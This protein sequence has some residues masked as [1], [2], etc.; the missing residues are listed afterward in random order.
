MAAPGF[1]AARIRTPLPIGSY[2]NV[3]DDTGAATSDGR[4]NAVVTRQI[5]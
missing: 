3:Q 1:G 5:G 2:V 4:S